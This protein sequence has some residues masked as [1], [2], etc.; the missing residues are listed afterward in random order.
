MVDYKI[1]STIQVEKTMVNFQI[2]TLY[3]IDFYKKK[4]NFKK[5]K[6]LLTDLI[7]DKNCIIHLSPFEDIDFKEDAFY[8]DI[9][10]IKFEKLSAYFNNY[11]KF[12]NEKLGGKVFFMNNER[13]KLFY[14]LR[15][16]YYS[17][18]ISK[19][20]LC[21]PSGIGKSTCLLVFSRMYY[22][23]IYFNLKEIMN[24]YKDKNNNNNE[25]FKL[26][27]YE[28][29]RIGINN[30]KIKKK[31]L[32]KLIELKRQTPW[33]I[34]K[35]IYDL[36]KDYNYN[37]ILL[38][39]QFKKQYIDFTIFD[40]MDKTLK[41]ES[42]LKI[43]LCSS[44]NDKD[45][46]HEIIRSIEILKGLPDY[47][48]PEN[49][50]YYYYFGNL[51]T[52][53]D[54]KKKSKKSVNDSYY[55]KFNYFDKYKFKIDNCKNKDDLL[56]E[57]KDKIIKKI[58]DDFN[59]GIYSI[60][61]IF[62]DIKSKIN[63]RLEYE[64]CEVILKFIPLKYL[65]I[66]FHKNYFE[67]NYS[68]PFIEELINKNIEDEDI[69]EY[70]KEK[71]YN[72]KNQ[73]YN[74]IKGDYFERASKIGLETENFLPEKINIHLNV[75]NIIE[76]DELEKQNDLNKYVLKNNKIKKKEYNK[77]KMEKI[78]IFEKNVN[79]DQP[80]NYQMFLALK[81]EKKSLTQNKRKRVTQRD[82]NNIDDINYIN[83]EDN[84]NDYI[85]NGDN[86]NNQNKKLEENPN[87]FKNNG[88]N[89]NI[90][91]KINIDQNNI[92]NDID[93]QI[94]INEYKDEFLNGNILLN[95][96]KSIGKIY[97]QAFLYGEKNSKIFVGFQMKFF[98]NSTTLCQDMEENL[99]KD[100]IIENSRKILS[101]LYLDFNIKIN[102][103]YYFMILFYDSEEKSYNKH[104]TEKCKEES[105]EYIFYDPIK[106]FF[107]DKNEIKIDQLKLALFADLNINKINN[108]F[109]I[110]RTDSDL[111][112]EQIN[113]EAKIYT[114][115]SIMN[116]KAEEF[117]SKFNTNLI[118][119][120][121]S[122]KNILNDKKVINLSGIFT[123]IKDRPMIS[124]KNGNIFL[125]ST[126][127]KN[128]LLY[129]YCENNKFYAGKL[130]EKKNVDIFSIGSLVSLDNFLTFH[131]SKI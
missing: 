97:D 57:I 104:L 75:Q 99:T 107:Y 40:D 17:D 32:A 39:D 69:F 114:D 24:L 93:N 121:R 108:P 20:K 62:S 54:L 119:V 68:F 65:I 110:F 7:T 53:E 64:N 43:I 111:Y 45:F 82:Q 34:F 112:Y 83:N 56:K 79:Q 48:C 129:L 80:M 14:Y 18:N 35:E 96:C 29:G 49:Q 51:T 95:Q 4:Q 102:R 28:L 77:K 84:E 66:S 6:I 46:R 31:F 115:N 15:Y 26:I 130:R 92:C 19:F 85:F 106:K 131:I 87:E 8:C 124:P 90:L 2:S 71:K 44:I 47:L 117:L 98:E 12:N 76:L 88:N 13:Q 52:L 9:K 116:K 58:Y 1:R 113:K 72:R 91:A 94:I 61:D 41:K 74:D 103:W 27:V 60:K 11:F 42:H 67:I 118:N 127:D 78:E 81:E 16:F 120:K 37:I 126:I 10:T 23:I 109:N 128:D 63:K 89:I 73:I 38:F 125:F 50:D 59:Y 123:L 122:L 5:W 101:K 21:G 30:D 33:N 105:L 3:F 25:Y 55:L 70:F 100:Y 86:Q 22:N 36:F